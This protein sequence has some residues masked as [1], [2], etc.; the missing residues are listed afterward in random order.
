MKVGNFV[1]SI[2]VMHIC[3]FSGITMRRYDLSEPQIGK[4]VC[5]RSSAHQETHASRFINEGNDINTATDLKATMDSHGGVKICKVVVEVQVCD[6]SGKPPKISE[7]S[8]LQNFEYTINHLRVWKAYGVC[9]V[10]FGKKMGYRYHL[11]N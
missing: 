7:I 2:S 11:H 9:T 5:D 1:I 8:Y 4:G 6:K 3:Q 10:R